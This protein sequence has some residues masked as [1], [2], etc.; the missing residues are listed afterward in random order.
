VKRGDERGAR[1]VRRRRE[2]GRSEAIPRRPGSKKSG[3]GCIADEIASIA[4]NP[5][6]VAS[7]PEIL[8]RGS[9]PTPAL[10]PPTIARDTRIANGDGGKTVG[11]ETIESNL[12]RIVDDDRS[13]IALPRD[14]AD[15]QRT[16]IV[17][18][19]GNFV[20]DGTNFFG[21]RSIVVRQQSIVVLQRSISVRHRT[22][23]VDPRGNLARFG[24]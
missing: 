7:D 1:V 9:A 8:A 3:E 24:S 12:A 2:A 21:Q 17:R 16:I 13:I 20:G 6:P 19:G 14:I 5:A 15:G 22:N 23:S 10:F 11:H 18:D 4:N